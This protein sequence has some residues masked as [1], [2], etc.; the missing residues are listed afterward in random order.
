MFRVLLVEDER[1]ILKALS[2][3]LEDDGYEVLHAS[4]YQEAACYISAFEC[5]LIISDLFF[6]S[7]SGDGI[8]L[9]NQVKQ[10][11]REIPFIA[12]TAFPE[13]NLAFQAKK[14]LHDRFF[15]KPFHVRQL[16]Q[17]I[18]EILNRPELC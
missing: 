18:S 5:D 6:G 9:L 17:K 3:E 12:M 7:K 13:T 2:F 10:G 8:Q 4:N 11:E 15:V 16:R 14:M 1:S